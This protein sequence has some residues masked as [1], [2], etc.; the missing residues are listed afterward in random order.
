MRKF[1]TKNLKDA[2]RTKYALPGGYE[3]FGITS[4]GAL[5]CCD[6]MRQE[7]R[8]IVWSIKHNCNDGWKVVAVDC[9]ANLE[10]REFVESNPDGYSLDYCAH[11]NK[12]F[13]Q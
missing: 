4:D 2:I 12:I 3:I 1:T 9:N 5:L 13:N 10:T 7:F 6:C 11:C 8:S